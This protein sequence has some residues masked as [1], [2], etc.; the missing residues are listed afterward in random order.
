MT[1]T[2]PQKKRP[3]PSSSSAPATDTTVPVT[4]TASGLTPARS[5]TRPTGTVTVEIAGRRLNIGVRPVGAA[6][7]RLPS[8]PETGPVDT[9][10]PTRLVAVVGHEG[11]GK[12]ALVRALG[13]PATPSGVVL[14]EGRAALP[15][16]DAVVFVLSSA[17]GLDP[18]LP[19]RWEEAAD[20]GLPRLVCITQL[21][22]PRADFDESVAV[23]Q[24]VLGEGVHP[25]AL[26]VLDDD[27]RVAGLL[28][29]LDLVLVTD[30]QQRPADPEHVALVEGLRDDLVEAVL[31]GSADDDAFDAWLDGAEPAPTCCGASCTPGSAPA[32]C[33][34]C[35]RERRTASGRG[36]ARPA[37]RLRAGR[38]GGRPAAGARRRRG[39]G[40]AGRGRRR[41]AAGAG[42]RR[43][44]SGSC[45]GRCCRGRS[46]V[47]GRP[48]EAA[49]TDLAGRPLP[50]AG[51]GR[52]PRRTCPTAWSAPS[53]GR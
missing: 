29:L 49:L 23:V 37:G 51:R 25:L 16:C 44:W 30:G 35:C 10:P 14:L 20:A 9:T 24:R 28:R 31:S 48:A 36:P 47:D 2:A 46:S 7:R 12:T 40:R 38:R 41:A 26:P 53:S 13:G 27:E 11:S 34:R 5:S 18:T 32:C 42:R 22:L 1:T 17:Q 15:L 45:P 52:V 43:A 21:D 6:A 33:T 50:R 8:R 19:L 4:V 39:G 3:V